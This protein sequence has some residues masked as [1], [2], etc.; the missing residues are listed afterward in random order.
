MGFLPYVLAK[1]I[2]E[3]NGL[4]VKFVR[5]FVLC[6]AIA[7]L[8][9]LYE[10]RFAYNLHRKIFDPFFPG[11]GDGWVTTFR[12]GLPRVAGPYAHAIL[13]G[14][15]L[16]FG[17]R[18]QLW[19]HASGVWEK[20]FQRFHIG[21][22]NKSAMLNLAM[23][24]GLLL[25]LVRGPIL[26][27]ILGG[28]FGLIGQGK[29]PRKRAKFVFLAML[30]VGVPAALSFWQYASV[31]RDNAK[32]SNQ[33]TAAY[34]KELIDKYV[35]IAMEHA[36][37]GWGR[38]GW[39]KISGMPSID[40]YYLLLALMHGVYAVVLL[41]SIIV[42]MMVRLYRNGMRYAPMK[43]PGSSLSFC[44]FGIYL[45]FMFSIA[46]VYMG[47]NVIP[48]FFLITGFADGYLFAGGDGV[49]Q[50]RSD[51]QAESIPVRFARVVC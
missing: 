16:L 35:A 40:N 21:P 48:V 38:N 47:E 22:L 18:L 5:S 49:L 25:T 37:L 31:G 26:G 42:L 3:P 29:N 24:G 9:T 27:A 15:M 4:R 43:P 6:M 44:L 8:S 19:L 51:R 11:Q 28:L 36:P 14:V 7:V 46:T 10:F 12:Y 17:V 45:G 50:E 30:I 1:G 34:R 13:A 32:D 2:I 39:P 41:I 23:M 20:R 33:E